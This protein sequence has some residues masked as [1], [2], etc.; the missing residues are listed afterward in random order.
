MCVNG[1]LADRTVSMASSGCAHRAV[2]IVYMSDRPALPKNCWQ[3]RESWE[4][5]LQ[6]TGHQRKNLRRAGRAPQSGVSF[7]P[8]N[9]FPSETA[10]STPH[11][12]G[13]SLSRPKCETE[14]EV[15][16]CVCLC[17]CL[18]QGTKK[19]G[20]ARGPSSTKTNARFL[21]RPLKTTDTLI[22]T[23]EKN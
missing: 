8:A 13:A 23:S 4:R 3:L 10:G 2:I 9:S 7:P 14:T 16:T 12:P 18:S 22:S 6:S 20:D 5:V 1:F 19:A 21:S 15:L 17:V 11:C